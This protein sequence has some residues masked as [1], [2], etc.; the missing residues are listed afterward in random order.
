M[1][2]PSVI[3]VGGGH[4]GAQLVTSLIQSGHA[5]RITLI[6]EEPYVPYQRPPLSKG[7]L[8]G[9]ILSE[10]LRIRPERYYRDKGVGLYLGQA[11][12]SFDPVARTVTLSDGQALAYDWLVLATGAE[13]IRPPLP[14]AWLPGVHCLR[15]LEDARLLDSAMHSVDRLV[16]IGGGYIGLEV[17]ASA[18]KRGLH[19][20]VLEGGDR[21]MSRSI[22][23]ETSDFL[24]RVHEAMGVRIHLNARVIS[25]R[26]EQRVEAVCL[27]NGSELESGLVVLGVGAR[28]RTALAERAC[29]DC[30]EGI[31]VNPIDCR[32]SYTQILAIGDCAREVTMDGMPGPR[33]ESVGNAMSQARIA[34][35][36]IMGADPPRTDV[37][38]FWTEQ[39]HHRIQIVGLPGTTE[40]RLLLGD[41]E[42]GC[43]AVYHFDAD[44][45]KAVE[46]VN[47]PRAFAEAKQL[48]RTHAGAKQIRA[49]D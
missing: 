34:A 33:M 3:V 38:S 42:R 10:S 8:T 7:L 1:E 46:A 4:A 13:A 47:H 18:R 6:S 41:P 23:P 49:W 45:L 2:H 40:E 12:H 17:A 14:G 26:G 9:E 15:N 30:N 19:V 32:S 39:Y 16:L 48:I 21:L 5:G 11:V 29:L 22:S 28:P 35:A 37:P 25:L 31:L 44:R 20:D 27:H 24:H 43:F 36:T